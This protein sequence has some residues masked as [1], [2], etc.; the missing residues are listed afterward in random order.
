MADHTGIRWQ[1]Q[2]PGRHLCPASLADLD[3]DLDQELLFVD[4]AEG[5]ETRLRAYHGDG[6]ASMVYDGLAL[7]IDR[8]ASHAP[9]AVNLNG[10]IAKELLI[11]LVENDPVNKPGR[12]VVVGSNGQLWSTEYFLAGQARSA[13]LILDLD[14]DGSLD[15][16]CQDDKGLTCAWSTGADDPDPGHV[17][18]DFRHA[19]NFLQPLP[20]QSGSCGTLAGRVIIQDTLTVEPGETLSAWHLRLVEGRL[21]VDGELN[22]V[23]DLVVGNAGCLAF[24]GESLLQPAGAGLDLMGEL[25]LVGQGVEPGYLPS[26]RTSISTLLNELDLRGHSGSTLRIRNCILN[27]LDRALSI[28]P[29]QELLMSDSWYLQSDEG[30]RM[31][32]AQGDFLRCLFQISGT[33]LELSSSSNAQ[34]RDCIFSSGEAQALRNDASCLDLRGTMFLANEEALWHG[35]EA[36][37]DVDSCHFQGNRYDVIVDGAPE[38]VVLRHSDFIEA[39]ETGVLNNASGQVD[40]REC[41]WNAVQPYVGDVLTDPEL[42][43]QVKPLQIP[44]PVFDVGTGPM[45]DGDEPLEWAPVDF[46]INGIPIRV[47]YRV[48]RSQDPYTVLEPDNLLVETEQTFCHDTERPN[49]AFYVVT[50]SFGKQV[51]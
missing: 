15:L 12:I 14:Q 49:P 37:S 43:E 47:T 48:Y 30:V 11:A 31:I 4:W 19:G 9:L 51:E 5:S 23:G 8:H 29:G 22:L 41:F 13:P 7:G 27:E 20:G 1:Q 45:V 18:G 25:S 35:P 40:A 46:T 24:S 50:T 32:Q 34:L 44:A 3:G 38:S 26:E 33:A 2:L 10:I 36:V 28:V 16:I 6:S 17:L 21:E 42:A 39:V